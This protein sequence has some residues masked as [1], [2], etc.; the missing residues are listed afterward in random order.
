M[1][2]EGEYSCTASNIAGTATASATI[3]V[4]SPPEVTVS[5]SNFIEAV[6]G[7]SVTVECR[8]SGYPQPMVSIR[9]E[10]NFYS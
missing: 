8:A 7:D 2:D 9:S 4:R 1:N 5:P 3:K 6:D 10:W